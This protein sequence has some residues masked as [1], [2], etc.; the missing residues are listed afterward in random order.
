MNSKLNENRCLAL[1]L[2]NGELWVDTRDLNSFVY[3]AKSF[4]GENLS[5]YITGFSKVSEGCSDNPPYFLQLILCE[6]RVYQMDES[7]EFN[8]LWELVISIAYFLVECTYDSSCSKVSL[9]YLEYRDI[10]R[11]CYVFPDMSEGKT[12]VLF[13]AYKVLTEG[14]NAINNS[15]N[16]SHWN[17]REHCLMYD[18][19]YVDNDPVIDELLIFAPEGS[20]VLDI[21]DSYKSRFEG[22]NLRN[23]IES[24]SVYNLSIYED[25]V[26]KGRKVV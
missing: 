4:K 13:N 7:I 9:N 1:V 19:S 6:D 11:R 5:D 8:S 15:L 23:L 26:S 16:L 18:C 12:T 17:L 20:P 3:V 24:R 2:S 10:L 25:L 22:C 21:S 14:A